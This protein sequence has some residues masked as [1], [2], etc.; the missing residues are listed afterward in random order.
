MSFILS[1]NIITL[2]YCTG[3]CD[4]ELR[5]W[6]VM[7]SYGTT[8]SVGVKGKKRNADMLHNN[9]DWKMKKAVTVKL[10]RNIRLILY[11]SF[12]QRALH[13]IESWSFQ[14]RAGRTYRSGFDSVINNKTSVR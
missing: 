11:P 1:R 7:D 9:T 6:E 10:L 5:L 8:L 13:K 3:M 12:T 14:F 2:L 4:N